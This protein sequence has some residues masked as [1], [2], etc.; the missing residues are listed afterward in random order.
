MSM[1]MLTQG[2]TVILPCNCGLRH[3]EILKIMIHC[4]REYTNETG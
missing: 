2:R 4:M 1:V 3:G